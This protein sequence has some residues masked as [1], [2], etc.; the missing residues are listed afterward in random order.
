MELSIIMNV[1]RQIDAMFPAF[2]SSTTAMLHLF[3]L[4]G[5]GVAFAPQIIS[6]KGNRI[7]IFGIFVKNWQAAVGVLILIG[8]VAVYNELIGS[9]YNLT[10][11]NG[12]GALGVLVAEIP[13][14]ILMR[15]QRRINLFWGSL[16]ALGGFLIFLSFV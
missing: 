12:Q 11:L 4:A 13:M 16:V 10:I 2:G 6:F 15:S 7:R 3:A 1:I 14:I 9:L 5:L 8:I